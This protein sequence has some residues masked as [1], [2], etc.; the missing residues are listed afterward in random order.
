[1][2]SSELKGRAKRMAHNAIK[3]IAMLPEGHPL[4]R[5]IEFQLAKSATSTYA[6]YRAACLASTKKN[7]CYK[8]DVVVEECDET[9][10]WLEFIKDENLVSDSV[11]SSTLQEAFEL[12]KIF[13]SSR[14][15]A[16]NNLKKRH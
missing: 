12:S 11:L 2:T 1:M 10:L 4:T 9:Y 3:V 5:V 14:M 6:N 8:M 16:R 7:F 15:T 13:I